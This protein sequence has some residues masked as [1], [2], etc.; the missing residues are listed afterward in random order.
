MALLSPFSL[1]FTALQTYITAQ[2]PEI[3]WIDHD[4]DQLET[5]ERPQVLF[6]ALLIDFTD[7]NY[8]DQQLSQYANITIRFRLCFD[9]WDNTS[10]VTPDARKEQG[11]Q[12]YEIEQKL[13]TKLQGWLNSGM[14]SLPFKRVTSKSEKKELQ[15]MRVRQIDYYCQYEDE[16]VGGA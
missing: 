12:Y 10:M 13:H 4:F 11:L 14:L 5:P 16:S 1:L 3:K 8:E 6:P 7:T 2:V 9:R 15:G